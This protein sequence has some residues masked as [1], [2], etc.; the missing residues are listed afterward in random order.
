MA[1]SF[2]KR[3]NIF[4]PG[5]WARKKSHIPSEKEFQV[6]LERERDRVD[7]YGGVFSVVSFFVQ[8]DKKGADGSQELI[9]ILTSRKLRKLDDIGWCCSSHIS[10]L[11]H[12]TGADGAEKYVKEIDELLDNREKKIESVIYTYP[13]NSNSNNGGKRLTNGFHSNGTLKNSQKISKRALF[14]NSVEEGNP[15]LAKYDLSEV[16]GEYDRGNSRIKNLF[17]REM[18]LW[19]RIVD[20]VGSVL[21]IILFS[22]IMLVTV[23]A[24]KLTSKGPVIFKQQRAGIGGK[25]FTCYKFRS[26]VVD[27][28][29]KKRELLKH[30]QRTGPVFKMEN[31]PRV[32]RVG[33]I[34]RKWSLDEMVQFFN[35]LKGDMSLVGP[36]PPTMDEVPEYINW[37]SR[38]L[39]IKP[40]ITCIWQVYSRHNK[41]FE[42]W[43]RQDIEYAQKRSFWLDLKILLLTLPAVLSRRGA[44]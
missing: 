21:F 26:M 22:P 7:R 16:L 11:L 36:R 31:D 1:I 34:I 17:T 20:I 37:H 23:V 28:E 14:V 30:N 4:N 6:I 24:I 39:D 9:N 42:N 41:C 13:E 8:K 12:N 10:F 2:L 27:A 32:T 38:R 35:V 44:Q 18:P 15:R 33:R 3:V 5:N 19:K 43:V 40:G 29:E 25:P